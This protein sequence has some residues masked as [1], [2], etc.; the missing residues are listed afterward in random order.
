MIQ[1][2]EATITMICETG[3]K[4][5]FVYD[6]GHRYAVLPDGSFYGKFEDS[7][8]AIDRSNIQ[9]FEITS[10]PNRFGKSIRL[11]LNILMEVKR[12]ERLMMGYIQKDEEMVIRKKIRE[13]NRKYYRK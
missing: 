13:I 10:V 5:I 8:G 6:D 7:T 2:S 1:I 11:I 12:P 3:A 9:G 4:V